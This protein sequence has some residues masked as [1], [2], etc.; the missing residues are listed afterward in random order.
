MASHNPGHITASTVSPFLTG[1]NDKLL[2]GGITAAKKIAMERSGLVDIQNKIF[3]GNKYTEWGNEHEADAIRRYEE[4]QFVTVHGQ[5][6]NVSEGWLSCT[7]DGL[8][9]DDGLVEVK[10]PYSE[11]VHLSYLLDTDELVK[12]YND[13]V[14]FQMMLTGRKWCDLVSYHPHWAGGKD[15]LIVRVYP[16]PAWVDRC[17]SRMEQVE[18]VVQEVLEELE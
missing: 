17:R 2:A 18:E 7:P 10:C 14:Q 16:D 15:L 5:Q 13:Q 9:G 12:K 1:K 8:V 3:E 4:E 11:Y 6:E